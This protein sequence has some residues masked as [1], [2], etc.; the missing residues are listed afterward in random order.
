MAADDE[1]TTKFKGDVSDLLAAIGEAKAALKAFADT[2]K[3]SSEESSKGSKKSGKDFDDFAKLLS[4][5]LKQGETATDAFNKKANELTNR[6]KSLKS[7]INKTGNTGLF[8]DLKKT[9]GD[10]S[11]V[12]GIL[13]DIG[14]ESKGGLLGNFGVAEAGAQGLIPL[15]IQMGVASAPFLVP[16]AAGSLLA[17][18]GAGGLALGIAG[19]LHNADIQVGLRGL[20]ADIKSTLHD[21]TAAFGPELTKSIGTVDTGITGFIKDLKPAMDALAPSLSVFTKKVSGGLLEA[22]PIFANAMAN[23]RPDVEALGGL[24]SNLTVGTAQF[25]NGLSIGAD[26][27]AMA[28]SA[29]GVELKNLEAGLG[30]DLGIISQMVGQVGQWEQAVNQA[31]P[32]TGFWGKALDGVKQ[33]AKDTLDPLSRIQTVQDGINK[34]F[35]AGTL[36]A[37][38]F[39]GSVVQLT[40]NMAGDGL[41]AAQALSQAFG[42]LATSMDDAFSSALKLD[43]AQLNLKQAQADLSA[44]LKK[45]KDNWDQ[46][47]QAGRDDWSQL[48]KNLSAIQKVHEAQVA[49]GG[50]TEANTAAYYKNVDALLATAKHAGLTTAEVKKLKDQFEELPHS[51]TIPIKIKVTVS[52]SDQAAQLLGRATGQRMVSADSN[53]RIAGRTSFADSGTFSGPSYSD[54]SD[55]TGFYG[56]RKGGLYRFAE[57]STGVEAL[58]SRGGDPGRGLATVAEAAGWFGGHIAP[59]R[60]MASGIDYSSPSHGGGA[61]PILLHS[62]IQVD[63]KTIVDALTPA[64]QRRGHRNAGVT[65]LG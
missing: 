34:V 56:G 57:A 40:G 12:E 60:T 20:G 29:L 59:G 42:D 6:I 54:S 21:S 28:I 1:T 10:L 33:A 27:G 53:T 4:R 61:G 9:Q 23:A 52:E 14:K 50:A 48:L 11:K 15:L 64:A 5:D 3:K 26:G 19:Q 8:G 41:S 63:G 45:N 31:G 62:I 38:G 37:G 35:G 16:L 43:Q 65:G 39:D 44:T 7:E 18:L 22:G 24:I 58:I 46:N 17:V 25:F 47:T 13:K 55:A 49:N 36:S 2:A 30:T 32:S 51:K